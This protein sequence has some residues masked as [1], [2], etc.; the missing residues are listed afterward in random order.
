MISISIRKLIRLSRAI[1]RAKESETLR[2]REKEMMMLVMIFLWNQR[3]RQAIFYL[4]TRL[5]KGALLVA[6]DAQRKATVRHVPQ[7]RPAV[8]AQ[9]LDPSY[10]A[11]RGLHAYGKKCINHQLWWIL[12]TF[13]F[14]SII[15]MDVSYPANY[16]HVYSISRLKW[17]YFLNLNNDCWGIVE[18]TK[19]MQCL[20]PCV[21]NQSL[22]IV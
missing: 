4:D 5:E 19:T 22:W 11:D 9:L 2:W 18:A 1:S 20:P 7:L 15:L 21:N 8:S 17:W 14:Y 12:F 3:V 13:S 16:Y 6:V 10:Y